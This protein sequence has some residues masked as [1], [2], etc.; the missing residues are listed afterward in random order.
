MNQIRELL[1]NLTLGRAVALSVICLAAT[2]TILCLAPLLIPMNFQLTDGKSSA[3]LQTSSS[4]CGE[5][6]TKQCGQKNTGSGLYSG[7]SNFKSVGHHTF[8]SFVLIHPFQTKLETNRDLKIQSNLQGFGAQKHGLN[9]WDLKTK[10][11]CEP[12]CSLIT[13][14]LAGQAPLVMRASMLESKSKKLYPMSLKKLGG[15]G[16]YL[17]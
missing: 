12:D 2:L 4:V 11:I 8:T 15:F 10:N 7:F 13:F 3:T 17:G 9:A 6:A 1:Q 5:D 16:A 14:A